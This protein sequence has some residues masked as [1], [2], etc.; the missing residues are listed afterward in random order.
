[1][2][3]QLQFTKK[4]FSHPLEIL[5]ASENLSADFV[6]DKKTLLPDQLCSLVFKPSSFRHL[7]KTLQCSSQASISL[8]TIK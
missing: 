6:V 1:M 4:D 7:C 3:M 2:N 5:L 8:L